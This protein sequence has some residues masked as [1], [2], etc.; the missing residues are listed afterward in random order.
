MMLRCLSRVAML[1]SLLAIGLGF[2]P[3]AAHAAAANAST[4]TVDYSLTSSSTILSPARTSRAPR[5]WP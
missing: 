5:S 2:L 3:M 4:T 1:G